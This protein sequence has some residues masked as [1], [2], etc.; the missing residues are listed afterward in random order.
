[1]FVLKFP[2]AFYLSN[3]MR[4]AFFYNNAKVEKRIIKLIRKGI[5]NHE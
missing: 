1:M 5:N 3:D 2:S 4:R